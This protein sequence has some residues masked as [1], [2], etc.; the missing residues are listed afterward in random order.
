[1]K[2]FDFK[3]VTKLFSF[4][5]YNSRKNIIGWVIAI[6]GIMSLYCF[7]FPMVQDIAS[8]KFDA[9]PKELLQLFGM[10]AM[11][12]M[13]NFVTYFGMVY[14][15]VIVA[16]CIFAVT[17][18]ARLLHKEEETKSI[19]FLS[20]LAVSRVEIYVSKLLVL[21]AG[22]MLVVSCGSIIALVAGT[23]VGGDTFNLMEVV[24]I[25]KICSFTPFFFGVIALGIAGISYKYGTGS[26]ASMGVLILY[27]LGYL[28][29]LLGEKGE[30]LLYLSPFATFDPA[31][32]IDLEVKTIITLGAYLAIAAAISYVGSYIY[33]KR[34]LKI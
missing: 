33:K 13:G 24:S 15:L 25:I 21:F 28:G 18:G 23:V 6:S 30:F 19:E 34:D 27:M 7:M 4:D 14:S 1:M 2:K 8:A 12:D 26:I 11:A 29:K 16:I 17:L 20:S 32:A 31:N 5:F 10:E 22:V 9:M 3:N